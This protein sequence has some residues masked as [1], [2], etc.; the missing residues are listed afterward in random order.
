MD[1]EEA[2]L[3]DIKNIYFAELNSINFDDLLR[4]R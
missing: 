3:D 2:S 1:G 4:R